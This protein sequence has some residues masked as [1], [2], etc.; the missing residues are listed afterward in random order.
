MVTLTEKR[1]YILMLDAFAI[2]NAIETSNGTAISTKNGDYVV[3]EKLTTV[4]QRIV[5]AKK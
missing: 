3:E 4:L 1:G 2:Q 5:E